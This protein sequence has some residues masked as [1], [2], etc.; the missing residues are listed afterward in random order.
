M[1]THVIAEPANEMSRGRSRSG[2]AED[3]V[4]RVWVWGYRAYMRV[5][6][7]R[8]MR[9]LPEEMLKDIGITSADAERE[10]SKPFWR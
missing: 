5:K 1:I 4:T 3:F 7:R 6:S 9:R 10:S 8:E 2:Y